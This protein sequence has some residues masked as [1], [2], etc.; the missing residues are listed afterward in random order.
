[1][2]QDYA[3]AQ[4]IGTSH[5][6]A[7]RSGYTPKWI[8][9][10][11]TAGGASADEVGYYFQTNDPPT[12]TH[13]IV[14]LNGEVVQCVAEEDTAWGNGIVTEGHDPWW[15]P[16]LNPNF[17]TFSV[18][19][20]KSAPDN[21]NTLTPAQKAASFAL[22]KHLCE[23]H[24]IPMRRADGSGGITGHNSIDPVS[25]A[26]C[27]GPYPW[28]E[29]I[30]YLNNNSGGANGG[31][32]RAAFT[33]SAHVTPDAV[34]T[35]NGW[36][37]DGQTLYAPNGQAVS[38]GFRWYIL[39][40]PWFAENWPLER[41]RYAA[42]LDVTNPDLGAGTLQHFRQSILAW[43]ENTGDILELWPGAIALRWQ[44]A[45][46][47]YE[48]RHPASAA[49]AQAGANLAG[50]VASANQ[51]G[52]NGVQQGAMGNRPPGGYTAPGAAG[53]PAMRP[54][55]SAQAA[56]AVTVGAAVG[57]GVASA[58]SVARAARYGGAASPADAQSASGSANLHGTLHYQPTPQGATP[59]A[60]RLG[61]T[62]AAA[63]GANS[64]QVGA[65]DTPQ[66]SGAGHGTPPA[67]PGA[68]PTAGQPRNGAQPTRQPAAPAND[69]LAQRLSSL[70]QQIL[71]LTQGLAQNGVQ[72]IGQSIE[73][74]LNRTP[75][76]RALGADLQRAAGVVEQDLANPKI[77]RRLFANPRTLLRWTLMILGLLFSDAIAWAITTFSQHPGAFPIPF[78]TIGTVFSGAFFLFAARLWV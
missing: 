12:S 48:R 61:A 14:G 21:S 58:A 6:W 70:E 32:N 69:P 60:A 13:F 67:A 40:H 50:A 44:E 62:H 53:A 20:V 38:L 65:S 31:A 43:S 34:G 63:G 11:G 36:R 17:L 55:A 37:D 22:I 18:E 8:I 7:G 49:S 4:W 16:N 51:R 27:P 56:E 24:N 26:F 52:A 2:S 23:R 75:Q 39:N 41:E 28:D 25:R 77:R 59:G 30:A 9:V 57:V 1:M 3:P 72:G 47:T 73:Q 46:E 29:L 64:A 19:H 42:P 33:A 10:H 76:G 15:S 66:A 78:L 45:A 71:A 68:R 5:F 54:V 74:N 35:P